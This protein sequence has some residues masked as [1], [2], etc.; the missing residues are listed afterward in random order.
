[1]SGGSPEAES[2]EH[3][4]DDLPKSHSSTIAGESLGRVQCSHFYSFSSTVCFAFIYCKKK[5]FL[6]E[7]VV[8]GDL[9]VFY[10]LYLSLFQH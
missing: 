6:R 7:S 5:S 10:F 3:P 8:G 4:V 2:K 1:M 9:P